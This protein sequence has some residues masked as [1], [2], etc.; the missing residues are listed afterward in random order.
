MLRSLPFLFLSLVMSSIYADDTAQFEKIKEAYRDNFRGCAPF[1]VEW[2][3]TTREC[4][5]RIIRDREGLRYFRETTQHWAKPWPLVLKRVDAQMQ[6]LEQ[7]LTPEAIAWRMQDKSH[8]QLLVTDLES[9]QY[10]RPY[11]EDSNDIGLHAET[12]SLTS[13]QLTEEMRNITVTTLVPEARMPLKIFYG[14]TK[15]DDTRHVSV[16]K[17]SFDALRHLAFPA[18]GEFKQAWATEHRLSP[19]DGWTAVTPDEVLIRTLKTRDGHDELHCTIA[20]E[21]SPD[22][23]CDRFDIWLRPDLGY[24]PIKVEHSYSMGPIQAERSD[25]FPTQLLSRTVTKDIRDYRSGYYPHEVETIEY[26]VDARW[27]S[28]RD[29]KVAVQGDIPT[30]E[31]SRRKQTVSYFRAKAPASLDVEM[32]LTANMTVHNLD[33]AEFYSKLHTLAEIT[34]RIFAHQYGIAS[35]L[36]YEM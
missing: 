17:E 36:P 34:V 29:P 10:R 35:V 11:P 9:L 7:R 28:T 5:G 16:A 30:L 22:N 21:G 23:R 13:E 6:E 31:D 8:K 15:P 26:T 14:T 27:Q 24:M 18:L 32:P 4:E 33:S 2:I 20:F 1:V 25:K 12:L 3:E 19:L